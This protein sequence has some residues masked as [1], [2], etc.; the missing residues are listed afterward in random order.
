ML[1][2]VFSI[3]VILLWIKVHTPGVNF[4]V[5]PCPSYLLQNLVVPDKR[6]LFW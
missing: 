6:E 5:H 3:V 2:A 1:S 4:L